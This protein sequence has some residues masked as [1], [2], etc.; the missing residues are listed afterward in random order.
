MEDRSFEQ[1]GAWAAVV[2]AVL[3]L[4]YAVAY[5]GRT[6]HSVATHVDRRVDRYPEYDRALDSVLAKP[7]QDLLRSIGVEE[8]TVVLARH[9]TP[10]IR[11]M[12]PPALRRAST[13]GRTFGSGRRMT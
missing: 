7:G 6:S 10:P 3:S 2:V 9:K 1:I 11:R 12:S 4:V 5:L 8:D 13:S